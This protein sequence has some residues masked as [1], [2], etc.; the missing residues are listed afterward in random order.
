MKF[1]K[2]ILEH[3]SKNESAY[4]HNIGFQEMV[5]F[6]KKASRAEIKKMEKIV[7]DE[8]WEEFKKLIRNTIGTK[9][10]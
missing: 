1:E 6:Y 4:P 5:E 10:V 3:L 8:D 9:L 7:K 2:H